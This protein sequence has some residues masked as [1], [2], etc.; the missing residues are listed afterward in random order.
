LNQINKLKNI[1]KNIEN[2]GIPKKEAELI[3]LNLYY[4]IKEIIIHQRKGKTND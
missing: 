2:K 4:S 1:I 3:A